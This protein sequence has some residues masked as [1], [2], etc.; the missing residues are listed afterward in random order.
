MAYDPVSQKLAAVAPIADAEIVAAIDRF[1]HLGIV[2]L[3]AAFEACNARF[4]T[5]VEAPENAGR[6]ISEAPD[7]RDRIAL[8]SLLER[9]MWWE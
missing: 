4:R 9:R 7:Y 5:W 3:Q 8:D 2:K 6:P 1:Q